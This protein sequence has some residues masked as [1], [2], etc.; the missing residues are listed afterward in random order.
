MNAH[1]AKWRYLSR[2]CH[3]STPQPL[4]PLTFFLQGANGQQTFFFLVQ[5][6]ETHSEVKPGREAKLHRI[7]KGVPLV[8]PNRGGTHR[9]G[10]G[11][12]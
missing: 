8:D 12:C 9:V 5:F 3:M 7:P 2:S 10:F 1:V 6:L 4:R 11:V